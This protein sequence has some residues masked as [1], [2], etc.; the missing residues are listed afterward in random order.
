MTIEIQTTTEAAVRRF[1]PESLRAQIVAILDAWGMRSDSAAT[2]ANVMVDTDLSAIDS[3]GVS[4]LSMYEK[5]LVEG[6]LDLNAE[7]EVVVDGPAFAVVDGHHGLGHPTGIRSME[8]AIEKAR[9]SG[10]GMVVVRNS[11]HFGALGFYARMASEQGLLSM[12]TTTTRTPVTSATG[13]TT[14]ILGTNPIAFS[15]PRVNGEPLLVDM[16]TSVVALNKVKAYANKSKTLPEGWVFDRAG[17]A[18]TDPAQAYSLLTQLGATISPLGGPT[19]E[20]GGHKGFG[21]SLM[22]QVLSAALSNA[23]GPLQAGDRDNIGHFFLVINPE[24]FNPGGQTAENVEHLANAMQQGEDGVKIPG[25][26]EREARRER[27]EN[28][29]PIPDVLFTTIS[30][31]AGRA[32]APMVLAEIV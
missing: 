29:I 5:F 12:V 20:T 10:I 24:A 26:P 7:P 22:S 15:A 9:K 32:S 23:A 1:T 30:E 19:P 31:I 28:G 18:V 11:L 13:G 27:G 17:E 3:H 8:L 14:P 16:S 2:T 21:L 4:M 6:R 25:D